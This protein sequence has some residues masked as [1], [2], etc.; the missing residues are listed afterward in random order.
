MNGFRTPPAL[1]LAASVILAGPPRALRAQDLSGQGSARF[2]ADIASKK[3]LVKNDAN[4]PFLLSHGRKTSKAILM[5]HGLSDSPYYMR[6]LAEIFYDAGY[7]VV[8]VLLPGHGTRPEDLL[9]IRL[10]QWK[11][12][13]GLGLEVAGQLGEE[14]SLAGF[15]TG[16]ALAL[17]LLTGNYAQRKPL[18]IKGLYLFSPAFEIAN[19]NAA[20][21]CNLPLVGR[22]KPWGADDPNAA[23]DNPHRYNKLALN[24]ACQ[25]YRLTQE[26]ALNQSETLSAIA[27]NGV[28]VFAVQSD[29]DTTV[30]TAAVV[31]F[32]DQLPNE[33]RRKFILYPKE[34]GIK[35]A[36]VTRPESNPFYRE[37]AEELRAFIDADERAPAP[38]PAISSIFHREILIR[39]LP[40]P[41]LE[42]LRVMVETGASF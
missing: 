41:A 2:E 39:S 24:G 22:F 30:K 27:N 13:V 36:A 35:H 29:P 23:E 21:A 6:S 18:A 14:V 25:L 3:T 12:E 32:M 1:I 40:S 8:A 19:D 38:M 5:V 17:N 20:L 11:K 28:S 42:S 34:A 15:S 16:G 4:L 37:L 9:D 10:K 26:N 33:V 31:A 7:N